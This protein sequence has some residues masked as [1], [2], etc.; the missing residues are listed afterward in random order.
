VGTY[1][2]QVTGW[3]AECDC[4]CGSGGCID[5]YICND[6]P[7]PKM[8]VDPETGRCK[9]SAA[10]A[11]KWLASWNS[12]EI[13]ITTKNLKFRDLTAEAANAATNKLKR[14]RIGNEGSRFDSSSESVSKTDLQ[15]TRCGET[16][17]T[18]SELE[19]L[20]TE[21]ANSQYDSVSSADRIANSVQT[22]AAPSAVSLLKGPTLLGQSQAQQSTTS[23]GTA[24]TVQT[25]TDA[26]GKCPAH[27]TYMNKADLLSYGL[28]SVSNGF[29]KHVLLLEKA[30]G[31]I[32]FDDTLTYKSPL[33]GLK[34][35]SN[36][37][38]ICSLLFDSNTLKNIL[39][40]PTCT[41]VT[42]ATKST[43]TVK[44]GSKAQI[45]AGY[46]LKFLPN[47]FVTDCDWP[48]LTTHKVTDAASAPTS[49]D[50]TFDDIKQEIMT[51]EDYN[52]K[53]LVDGALGKHE[54][55]VEYDS[56]YATG[57]ATALATA[58][59]TSAKTEIAASNASFSTTGIFKIT[60]AQLT[61][62]KAA[63][64]AKIRIK[65]Q[66]S[67]DYGQR[68]ALVKEVTLNNAA[69]TPELKNPPNSILYD[70]SKDNPISFEFSYTNCGSSDAKVTSTIT[71]QKKVSGNFA[72][73]TVEAEKIVN[74]MIPKGLSPSSEFQVKVSYTAPGISTPIV[75]NIP[76]QFIT[77]KPVLDVK[78]IKTFV[79]AS[80]VL[81]FKFDATN[82]SN[83]QNLANLGIT[84]SCATCTGTK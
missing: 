29:Y 11:L 55:S 19:V 65:A 60:A 13:E 77:K 21:L 76:L 24:S 17:N 78:G 28:D 34:F 49:L 20:R 23:S 35:T 61:K 81:T 79:K 63:T 67:D 74:N 32:S 1:A 75:T 56:A 54:C 30:F 2:D 41:L 59:A 52:L 73:T 10:V 62:L 37:T 3:C 66:C 44:V 4:N 5:R 9:C 57:S 39:D 80:D 27:K 42:T 12:I 26:T 22:T 25:I 31:V 36:P 83:V 38:D 64:A 14:C 6:C 40:N 16:A 48:V 47:V 71:L 45:Y 58:D 8:A 84:F 46:A 72:D 69:S 43:I 82:V 51:C 68:N 53:I 15:I 50:I 70:S 7:N 18:D 33:D